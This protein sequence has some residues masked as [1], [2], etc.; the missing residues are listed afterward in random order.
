M[1]DI[2]S[3]ETE[4]TKLIFTI[5]QITVITAEKNVI[6]TGNCKLTKKT[7]GREGINSVFNYL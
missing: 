2:F 6:L 4:F 7:N 1:A 3:T 5:K